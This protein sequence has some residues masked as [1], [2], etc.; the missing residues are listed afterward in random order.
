MGS[1][2][3][4][5][6]LKLTKGVGE[7]TL[8]R[9]YK[10]FG[11]AENILSADYKDLK[12]CV[13]ESR[14]RAIL[15]GDFDEKVYEEVL[16]AVES[17]SIYVIT[18]EDEEYPSAL[19]RIKD[20]PPLVFLRGSL[21]KLPL[22]GIVGTRK[23]TPYTLNFVEELVSM[24]VSRGYGVVSGGAAGVDSKAHLSAVEN[25]GYT[26]CI[27]GFGILKARG[28]VFES[29]SESGGA[30]LSE[31][32]PHERGDRHTFPKRN[33]LIAALS[34]FIVVP[35]AGGSSGSLITADHAVK[36]GKKVYAHIGIGRSSSWDGCYRLVREGKAEL[37]KDGSHVFG[38]K[39]NSESEP[40]LEFLRIPRSLD[41]VKTFL[42]V[43]D[44]EALKLLT[45]LEL[46]GKIKRLG[47]FFSS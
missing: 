16:R 44:S 18:L 28:K 12:G 23:P 7:I 39:E 32:L 35:E 1:F 31:F 46:E 14:A 9:L 11:G 6:R 27:L 5:L 41:D 8:Y 19:K 43:D 25:S 40:L 47:S 17:G 45:E 42:G 37:I 33:R 38:V 24:A 30:L 21:R 13:G 15:S 34:E 36:Q 4:W 22:V 10:T 2:E 20:P 26:L 29:I 3:L